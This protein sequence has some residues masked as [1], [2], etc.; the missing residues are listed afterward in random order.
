MT[1]KSAE[2][3]YPHNPSEDPD[4]IKLRE[5]LINKIFDLGDILDLR[6]ITL[7]TAII[8]VEKLLKNGKINII[9]HDKCLWAVTS[10]LLACKYIELDDDIPSINSLLKTISNKSYTYD[11]VLKCES[12]FLKVLNWDLMVVTPLH[13]TE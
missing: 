3:K 4:T 10:L 11:V 12:V 13:Y 9:S 2:N 1:K 6:N 8:Y 7:Q 5:Y